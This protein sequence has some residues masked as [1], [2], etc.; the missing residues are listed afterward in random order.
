MPPAYEMDEHERDNR[1]M[2]ARLETGGYGSVLDE[3]LRRYFPS[4]M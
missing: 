1:L 4:E 3:P 2:S